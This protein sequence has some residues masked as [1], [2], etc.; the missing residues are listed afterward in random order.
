MIMIRTSMGCEWSGK[1]FME[2]VKR[3]Q[4]KPWPILRPLR[5]PSIILAVAIA[6]SNDNVAMQWIDDDLLAWMVG[7]G[8]AAAVYY[9]IGQ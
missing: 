8:S 2:S 6:P 9:C 7:Y 4:Q 3:G 1:E 5:R